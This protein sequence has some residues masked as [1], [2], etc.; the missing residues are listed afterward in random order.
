[1]V[2]I[3]AGLAESGFRPFAYTISNFISVRALEQIRNDIVLH[4]L[5]VTLVG[6]STGFDNGPLGPT[7]H[8]LDDWGLLS[9]MPNL[10]IYCPCTLHG[11][12]SIFS[13]SLV[14]NSPIYIR[15]PKGS[16]I[17]VE[18]KHISNRKSLVLSYG[19]TAEY[20]IKYANLND[21]DYLL[22]EHLKPLHDDMKVIANYDKLIVI[23]DHFST[24]GL[25]SKI[26][27]LV[28]EIEAECRVSS[29]SPSEYSLVVGKNFADFL[30]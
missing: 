23:E 13:L 24:I 20:A 16:G 21:S 22:I 9:G 25:Y 1:M 7:H 30:N 17:Q 29:I 12:D 3:A 19:S 18:L 11:I 15:I 4:K 10:D 5:P 8:M 26:C 2:G 27:Q 28:N 14:S 6:T